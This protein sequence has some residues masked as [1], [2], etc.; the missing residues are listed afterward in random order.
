MLRPHTQHKAKQHPRLNWATAHGVSCVLC[1]IC[2]A[3]MRQS[4]QASETGTG[5]L[6][7]G[8]TDLLRGSGKAA[9][10]RGFCQTIE[11]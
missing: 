6:A 9:G 8:M 4:K 5:G 2:K 3:T 11:H 10:M 1:G 7:L